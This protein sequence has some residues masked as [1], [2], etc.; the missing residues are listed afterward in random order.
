MIP[1]WGSALRLNRIYKICFA[2][3]WELLL[4][5]ICQSIYT[6]IDLNIYSGEELK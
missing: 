1:K 4:E 3:L 6:L 2:N 5:T